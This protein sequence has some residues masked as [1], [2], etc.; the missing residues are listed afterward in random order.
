MDIKRLQQVLRVFSVLPMTAV[1]AAMLPVGAMDAV[2]RYI[3]LGSLPKGPIVEYLAR[4]TSLFYALHGA[5][6]WYL[7]SDL[8]RYRDVFWFY[9]WL[10]LI[11]AVGLFL[12]DL[13][14]GLPPRWAF[15][16]GPAVAVLVGLIMWLFR[17]ADARGEA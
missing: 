15:G 2:H 3:G 14:A 12:T 5:L 9:L 1:F 7:A 10:S 13:T 8:R 17:R 6:L 4:S 16:E 11:F